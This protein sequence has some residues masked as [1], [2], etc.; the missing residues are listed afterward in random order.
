[1]PPSPACSKTRLGASPICSRQRAIHGARA[2]AT[3]RRKKP[4]F[5]PPA[6]PPHFRLV[7]ALRLRLPV[8]QQ[9]GLTGA[10][11][12]VAQHLHVA[13]GSGRGQRIADVTQTVFATLQQSSPIVSQLY[14][15]RKLW[16]TLP[17]E[18]AEQWLQLSC[19][20]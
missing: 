4:R 11:E 12:L 10:D 20:E 19:P 14:A 15:S 6:V 9:R 18:S 16:E 1:M 5:Q 17:A 13:A 7:S 3:T 8:Q 2:Q